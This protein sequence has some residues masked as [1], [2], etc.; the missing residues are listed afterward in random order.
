MSCMTFDSCGIKRLY[1]MLK[2]E[3][4][5][6]I[7]L[8]SYDE[9]CWSDPFKGIPSVSEFEKHVR[10]DIISCKVNLATNEDFL[11]LLEYTKIS[12]TLSEGRLLNKTIHYSD[13]KFTL[14]EIKAII[15]TYNSESGFSRVPKGIAQWMK[16][17]FISDKSIRDKIY[18]TKDFCKFVKY[19]GGLHCVYTDSSEKL[20]TALQKAIVTCNDLHCNIIERHDANFDLEEEYQLILFKRLWDSQTLLVYKIHALEEANNFL[21][22]SLVKD[23]IKDLTKLSDQLH[24]SQDYAIVK[25]TVIEL[26]NNKKLPLSLAEIILGDDFDGVVTIASI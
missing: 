19:H 11:K 22:D 13:I 25:E 4:E 21:K 17:A 7:L 23:A 3:E 18:K 2:T 1:S 10:E 6:L 8:C 14:T 15:K 20:P 9:E 24:F 12:N 26:L 5:R 16:S